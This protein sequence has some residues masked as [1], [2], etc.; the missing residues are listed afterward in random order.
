MQLDFLNLGKPTAQE[1]FDL[2]SKPKAAARYEDAEKFFATLTA[3]E[4]ATYKA[5][6]QSIAPKNDVEKFQRWLFAFL[7]VHST[8][9]SNVA[10]YEA[11]KDWTSWF[12]QWDALEQK[13]K[14]SRIG[15]NNMRL[16]FLK[17]FA[18]EYWQ[19]PSRYTKGTDETWGQCRDRLEKVILG[20]G[21]AKVSFAL[22]ML[23]PTEAQ[24]GCMDV[25]LYRLYGL[26]QGR[27]ATLGRK[28][29]SHFVQMAKLWNTP[30]ALARAILWDR[31]QGKSDSRY[32][33]YVFES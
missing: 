15:L 32:W 26:Q 31:R 25:H 3:T 6:W 17:Q 24:V 12:N 18:K 10:G 14:D 20:L 7:S 29:E 22:E 28:I 23:H 13:I 11:L 27:D 19:N 4:V 16:R 5:Y 30:P 2:F 33:S 8:W 1:Q 9:S 21:F